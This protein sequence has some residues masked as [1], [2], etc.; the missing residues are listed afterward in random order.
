[1]F[2][3]SSKLRAADP[4]R[5]SDVEMPDFLAMAQRI[6]MSSATSLRVNYLS[7][8]VKIAVG[9]IAAAMILAG[10][11]TALVP[12]SVPG[13]RS[14]RRVMWN[15]PTSGNVVGKTNGSVSGFNFHFVSSSTLSS[16]NGTG[17]L[18]EVKTNLRPLNEIAKFAKAF[19]V[20]SAAGITA[21]SQPHQSELVTGD[22]TSATGAMAYWSYFGNNSTQY[23][24]NQFHFVASDADKLLYSNQISTQVSAADQS[25]FLAMAKTTWSSLRPSATLNASL[26]T[27]QVVPATTLSGVSEVV[28]RLSIPLMVRGYALNQSV[29][30]EYLASGQLIGA[31]GPDVSI[32]KAVPVTIQAPTT[33]VG[34]V[35]D[36]INTPCDST[37]SSTVNASAVSGAV[38]T[39][40]TSGTRIVE[41]SNASVLYQPVVTSNK[42][43]WLIPF[44]EFSGQLG[45]TYVNRFIGTTAVGTKSVSIST[46]SNGKCVTTLS[47][48]LR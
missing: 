4:V 3:F 11:L 7:A 17:A 16:A 39:T 31:T 18:Y 24:F 2:E 22:A 46:S 19:G 10:A 20:S 30:F 29:E 28:T 47:R 21:V 6:E 42:S 15:L 14:A 12:S 44:Y 36:G 38:V 40:T 43:V 5:D 34:D 27:W 25:R 48:S 41:I 13:T 9:A 35:D 33:A 8:R 37:Y 32:V 1:M 23:P 45:S 26:A